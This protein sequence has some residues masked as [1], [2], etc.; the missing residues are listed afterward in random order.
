MKKIGLVA[1]TALVATM[2]LSGC[3]SN[4]EKRQ[5]V[6]STWGLSEDILQ[7]DVYAPF[8]KLCNC[9]VVL[10]TG[11]TAER[12]QKVSSDTATTVDVIELNQA[13]TAKGVDAG[14]FKDITSEKIANT[15]DLIPAAKELYEAG[16]GVPYTLNSIGIV[17]DKAAVG[18]EI[19]SWSDL[20]NTALKDSV[21]IPSIETTFGPAM[22]YMA[23][24]VAG[25]EVA[26]DGGTAGIAKLAELK[27][28]LV[29]TYA[30][31]ADLTNGFSQGE[32]KVAIVGDFGY[33]QIKAAVPTVEYVVPDSGTYA[34][35]NIINIMKN[36]KNADLA[37]K[38]LNWRIDKDL[39]AT[40]ANPA[41]LNEAPVNTKTVLSDEFSANKTYGEIANRAAALDFKFVNSKLADWTD[42]F[43]KTLNQ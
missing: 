32:I 24:D 34:N 5:L 7:S 26:T 2:A 19:K 11:T 30:K 31:S 41:T 14:L 33:P 10:D 18:F 20:W 4:K 36:S 9:T 3:S 43:N 12:Y 8:E 37:L 25:V 28:N 15:A 22:I 38:Y 35:F 40:N 23:S 42:R 39:Q 16:Q 29:K 13:T 6:I 27:S 17:Y 21:S 1:A